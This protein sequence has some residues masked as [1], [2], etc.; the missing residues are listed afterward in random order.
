M[1]QLKTDNIDNKILQVLKKNSKLSYRG[2]SKQLLIP[3][4]TVHHRMRKLE[5]NGIIKKYTVILDDK[6]LGKSVAAYVL[7]KVDYNALNSKG[8]TQKEL[9]K[10]LKRREDIEDVCLITGLRDIIL[11]IR[12]HSVD[13]L[14]Q[15][16]TKDLRNLTGIKSTETMVILDELED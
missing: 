5:K 12:T 3:V 8:L 11:K 14:N 13:E 9:A 7:V 15:L 2:I 10:I 1:G 6:K 4:T 16:L